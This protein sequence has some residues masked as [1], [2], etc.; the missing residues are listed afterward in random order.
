MHIPELSREDSKMLH[1]LSI[2]LFALTN[3]SSLL[4]NVDGK[5]TFSCMFML[6]VTAYQRE[7][8]LTSLSSSRQD[9]DSIN[10][11]G[12]DPAESKQ[13]IM[14]YKSDENEIYGTVSHHMVRK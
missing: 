5:A 2:L 6:L 12:N 4:H 9:T 3:R 13:L 10:M 7:A 14:L 1:F 11:G 8:V